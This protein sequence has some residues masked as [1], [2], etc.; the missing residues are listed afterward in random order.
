MS[1]WYLFFEEGLKLKI[2]FTL[3]VPLKVINLSVSVKSIIASHVMEFL[4][5]LLHYEV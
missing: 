3:L 2:R 5:M 1:E 4:S